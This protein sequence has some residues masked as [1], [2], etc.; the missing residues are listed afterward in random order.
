MPWFPTDQTAEQDKKGVGLRRQEKRR[1]KSFVHPCN[2]GQG[3]KDFLKRTYAGLACKIL[4]TFE[5]TLGDH[6]YYQTHK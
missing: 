6:Q 2:T 4:T 5:T 3:L 1:T